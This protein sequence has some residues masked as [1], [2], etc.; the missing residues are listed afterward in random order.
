MIRID[1]PGQPP[2]RNHTY[3]IIRVKH[4]DGGSH[5]Q[6][7]KVP[8]VESYQLVVSTLTRRALGTASLPSMGPI[9][10]RYWFYVN[11]DIDCDNAMKALNDA[12]AIGLGVDDKRFLPCVV[13]KHTKIKEP[14]VVI[15]IEA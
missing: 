5:Q 2:S 13:E 14:H 1:V 11:R 4:R 8:G 6:L 3:R 10:L 9:R 12:I 7:G 15:E